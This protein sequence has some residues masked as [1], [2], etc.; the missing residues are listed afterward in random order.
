MCADKTKEKKRKD[1]LAALEE[2]EARLQTI[3]NS[4]VDAIIC[5]DDRGI[6]ESFNYAAERIFG[7]SAKEVIGKN[8]NILIPEGSHK[9]QH[10]DYLTQH[11]QP[12]HSAVMGREREIQAQHKDGGIFP[13]EI[14]LNEV[15]VSGKRK[16]V[17]VIRDITERKKSDEKVIQY[18]DRLEWAHYETQ[19]ARR[20]AE[21]ANKAKSVFLANM[22]HEIRT[23]LNGIIGMTEL[24]LNTELTEQQDKFANRIYS[25]GELLLTII[26]DVL[27]FSKI[28][29]GE[30]K[31]EVIPTNIQELIDKVV[32][33]LQPKADQKGLAVD[34]RYADN[35][36]LDIIG[37]PIRLGQIIMNLVGN[38]LKFTEK[39]SVSIRVQ[40]TDLAKTGA[41]L[42]F[43]VADTGRGIAEEHLGSI[44][45]KFAQ[46]DVST[47]RKF[48]G[49]GLGLA[50]CKQLVEMMGGKIGVH[51]EIDKGSTFWFEITFP[52]AR[53]YSQDLMKVYEKFHNVKIMIVDNI[54][55]NCNIIEEY[56]DSWGMEYK[57]CSTAANALSAL[58]NAK[59]KGQPFGIALIDS[60][61]KA[62]KTAQQLAETIKAD[63]LISDTILIMLSSTN[64][65]NNE[66]LKKTGFSTSLRKPI[67]SSELFDAMI[68]SWCEHCESD[69]EKAS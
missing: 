35:T 59:K 66:G 36:P 61:L 42:L 53:P 22:S 25:S 44:F 21:R 47:T 24:L 29:A 69:Q 26:N 6:I 63:P 32:G 14:A 38:A 48:G 56:A 37:D 28:E 51:S 52:L 64:D 45:D 18:T 68:G 11:S 15:Q 62:D 27:D 9:T 60:D 20:E 31:L 2:S 65:D 7:Y 3:L 40:S 4:V 33:I 13:V 43:E 55:I 5:I 57:S 58:K 8:V 67:Y 1:I 17:G 50:I 12:G 23:P 41:T 16:F 49:T 54:E 10:D 39:G 34:I 30:M 19:Q 46:G